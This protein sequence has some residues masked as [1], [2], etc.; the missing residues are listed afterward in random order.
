MDITVVL[1]VRLKKKVLGLS[2]LEKTK[3]R[4]KRVCFLGVELFDERTDLEFA[5]NV[6]LGTYQQGELT[7][8]TQIPRYGSVSDVPID[9]MH[10]VLLGI[11]KKLIIL[12]L[13]GPPKV[14]VSSANID[15][16]ST[17]LIELRKSQS[18][19]FARRP[20]SLRDL[21][22]WKATEFRNFLIYSGPIFLENVLKEEIYTNFMALHVAITI[23][24]SPNFNKI[25]GEID[26]AQDLIEYF[27]Q[28]LRLFTE[29]YSYRTTFIIYFTFARMSKNM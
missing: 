8:L 19:E 28:T 12:W 15:K 5:S 11:M 22:G 3:K 13:K 20:R 17:N 1:N 21:K 26:Y 10:L 14:R 6:Y 4:K 2:R 27:I 24:S 29:K 9:Y 18:S 7:I 23:V 16:I 25:P